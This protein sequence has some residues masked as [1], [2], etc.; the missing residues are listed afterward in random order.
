MHRVKHLRLRRAL[1]GYPVSAATGPLA[2][3][4]RSWWTVQ[5]PCG[6]TVGMGR[7]WPHKI[8]HCPF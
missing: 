4:S 5:P 8:V 2:H 3:N 6:T 7:V 1:E